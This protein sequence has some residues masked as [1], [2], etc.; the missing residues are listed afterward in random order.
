MRIN[1]LYTTV[2]LTSRSSELVS[3]AHPPP[4]SLLPCSCSLVLLLIFN[5]PPPALIPL[6]STAL[7]D[8]SGPLISASFSCTRIA[9]SHTSI[10]PLAGLDGVV[11]IVL[12]LLEAVGVIVSRLVLQGFFLLPACLYPS[13]SS[14]S[15]SLK[16]PPA[17]VH[18]P[19]LSEP[20]QQ[21]LTCTGRLRMVDMVYGTAWWTWWALSMQHLEIVVEPGSNANQTSRTRSA[22]FGPE[23]GQQLNLNLG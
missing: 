5:F 10:D 21:L 19:H 9:P 11:G 4:F 17:V 16:A 22:V 1:I 8:H 7:L 15:A 6:E 23:F 3:L 12:L 18:C 14:S 2:I 13:F 20:R